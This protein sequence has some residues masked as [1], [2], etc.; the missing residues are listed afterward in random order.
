MLLQPSTL[1]V[2]VSA[3]GHSPACER[4]VCQHKLPFPLASSSEDCVLGSILYSLACLGLDVLLYSLA[5]L[6]LD[7]LF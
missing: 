7:V 5:C 6:G 3:A 4:N 2:M 1:V